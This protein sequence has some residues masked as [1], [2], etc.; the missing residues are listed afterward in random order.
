M[1]A[2]KKRGGRRLGTT[3]LVTLAILYGG[4]A[5]ARSDQPSFASPQDAVTAL[6]GALQTHDAGAIGKVLGPGSEAL[7]RSGDAV[8]DRAQAMNFLQA[9]DAGHKIT[10]IAPDRMVIQVGPSDWPMPIPIV[11]TSGKW[12][13]DSRTGAQEIINRRIGRNEIAAIRICLAY[14]D[15]QHAYFDMFRQATGTGVYAMR[16]ASTSGNYDGLYWPSTPGI[17]ESP[18]TPLFTTAVSEGYSS[19]IDPNNPVPYE[20]YRYRILTA[21]GPDAPDGAKSYVREGKMVDGFALIAWPAIYGA[22]GIMTFIVGKEGVVFQKDLGPDTSSRVARV[23]TFNP[24][25][26][27]TKIDTPGE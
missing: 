20:G 19:Q 22:S 12:R 7:V 8:K 25:L 5:M 2:D 1:V 16:L 15:A 26:D 17:P 21:S 3:T 24:D 23:V 11:R 9:Y 13:F 4:P 14:V 27:W 6:V 10:P 18:L